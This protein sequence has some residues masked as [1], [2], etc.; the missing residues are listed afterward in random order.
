MDNV[1]K[2]TC[3]HLSCTKTPFF[4]VAGTKKAEFCSPHAKEGMAS[5]GR[6]CSRAGCTKQPQGFLPSA[7]QAVHPSTAISTP[8]GA[9]E[10]LNADATTGAEAAPPTLA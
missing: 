1:R 8:T 2:R 10:V 4:G 9:R 7:M 6:T 3:R 5:L